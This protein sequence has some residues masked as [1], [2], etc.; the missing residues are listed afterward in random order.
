LL[1]HDDAGYGLLLERL[2]PG[3]TFRGSIR[4]EAAVKRALQLHRDFPMP[5]SSEGLLRFDEWLTGAF[6]GYRA[7]T[8]LE[9]SI[10]AHIGLTETLFKNFCNE[11]DRLLHGDCHHENIL[12]DS[13]SWKAVDPKGVIGPAI[14][15]SGRFLH[16]FVEDERDVPLTHQYR[17]EILRRRCQLASEV[18]GASLQTL[19]RVAFIDATLSTCWSVNSGQSSTKALALLAA[20][21][22]LID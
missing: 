2:L 17:I 21:K 18:L 20:L 16:N 14:L 1:D 11:P 9:P 19:A 12:L 15:E 3:E 8:E 13:E 22:T 7:G 10:L 6:A 4:D 5:V